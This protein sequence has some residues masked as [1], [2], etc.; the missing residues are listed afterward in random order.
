M[1]HINEKFKLE[2]LKIIQWEILEIKRSI[3]EIK[4][5]GESLNSSLD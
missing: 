3:S 4:T 1:E 2:I 5:L